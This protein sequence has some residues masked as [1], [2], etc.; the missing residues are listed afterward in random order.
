MHMCDMRRNLT[1]LEDALRDQQISRD[2]YQSAVD[3]VE[4]AMMIPAIRLYHLFS[5]YIAF[6][7]LTHFRDIVE[8][9]LEDAKEESLEA[10]AMKCYLAKVEN[11]IGKSTKVWQERTHMLDQERRE[12]FSSMSTLFQEVSY[13]NQILK[14]Q[15][16]RKELNP[17]LTRHQWDQ[18]SSSIN[19]QQKSK[20]GSVLAKTFFPRLE[21]RETLVGRSRTSHH[22]SPLLWRFPSS[23][24]TTSMDLSN[25]LIERLRRPPGLP[26]HCHTRN[27]TI[28]V[29]QDCRL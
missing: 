20:M 26:I 28:T 25:W 8:T 23:S 29:H 27:S 24:S 2:M 5:R 19:S 18:N 12:L 6:R 17:L 14:E 21:S 3:I 9:H 22:L 4:R 16:T 13:T 7:R 1:T 15:Q 10:S 11:N